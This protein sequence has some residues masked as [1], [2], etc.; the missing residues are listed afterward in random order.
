MEHKKTYTPGSVAALLDTA[1]FSR[2][3]TE[4]GFFEFYLNLWAA[5]RKA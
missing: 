3:R 5:A 2:E 4:I 1:G